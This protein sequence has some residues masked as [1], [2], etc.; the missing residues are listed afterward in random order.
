[1]SSLTTDKIITTADSTQKRVV[2][3]TESTTSDIS[4]ISIGKEENSTF[5]ETSNAINRNKP[6]RIVIKRSV[7][8][9]GSNG[10]DIL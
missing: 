1:M 8:N 3:N 9:V 7:S 10:E 2:K 6:W 5:S 4:G